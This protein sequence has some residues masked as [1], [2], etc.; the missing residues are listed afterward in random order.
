M[1]Y[2][3]YLLAGIFLP[4]FPLGAVF[5]ALFQRAREKLKGQLLAGHVSLVKGER[6]AVAELGA[7]LL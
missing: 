3:V 4:L 6:S 5:N 1:T 2:I 7:R